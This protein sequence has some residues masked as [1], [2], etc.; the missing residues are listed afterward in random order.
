M[1]NQL[2]TPAVFQNPITGQVEIMPV[3]MIGAY[4]PHMD[5]LNL[6]EAAKVAAIRDEEAATNLLLSVVDPLGTKLNLSIPE[7]LPIID[8][9][10]IE[11]VTA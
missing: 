7:G 6:E 3:E 9:T 1:A 4:V 10:T 2:A 8:E 11:P 5:H